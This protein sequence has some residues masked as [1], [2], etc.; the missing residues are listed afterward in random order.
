MALGPSFSGIY[1]ACH[2]HIL[3]LPLLK[4]QLIFASSQRRQHVDMSSFQGLGHINIIKLHA[5]LFVEYGSLPWHAVV[6]MS[7][8]S[9]QRH[10]G[11]NNCC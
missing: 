11:R 2:G 5:L 1:A 4:I 8:L 3:S 10:P 7:L 9:L 6:E